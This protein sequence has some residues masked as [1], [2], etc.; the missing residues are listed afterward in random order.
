MQSDTLLL[1]GAGG[2]GKVVLEAAR[3][4][5]WRHIVLADADLSRVGQAVDGVIVSALGAIVEWPSSFHVCIG[6]SV[7]RE[8]LNRLG[9]TAGRRNPVIVHP[10]SQLSRSARVG[11]G[12]FI[13]ALAIVGPSANVG[14]GV[15]VNHGAVVDHDVEVGD[16]SHV[17]PNATL[18]GSVRI[19]QGCLVGAGAV[20]LPGVVI[21]AKCV[22]GA[23]AVVTRNVPARTT[24][25]GIPARSR[26]EE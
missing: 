20:V 1:I 2:H 3:T 18:G 13:A 12:S 5:G 4:V 7:A 14:L 16:W 26:G 9:L 25:M 19:G 17:A 22:V 8:S 6:N 15:I 21:G 10:A 23:G 11:E 24:V